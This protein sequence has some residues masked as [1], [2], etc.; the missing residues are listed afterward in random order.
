MKRSCWRRKFIR[1]WNSRGW[2][3]TL[4]GT[5]LD[6]FIEGYKDGLREIE[7]EKRKQGKISVKIAKG[8][9]SPFFVEKINIPSLRLASS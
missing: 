5:F 8:A 1:S 9:G 7:A 3:F 2:N 4:K 6:S